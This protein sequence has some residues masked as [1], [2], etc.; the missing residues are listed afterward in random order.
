MTERTVHEVP[1]EAAEGPAAAWAAV[2]PAARMPAAATTTTTTTL[3]ATTTGDDN[4]GG[5]MGNERAQASDGNNIFNN[6]RRSAGN[7]EGKEKGK[8]S[9][10]WNWNKEKEKEKE[11]KRRRESMESNGTRGPD[12]KESRKDDG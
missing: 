1:R 9:G 3:R 8:T 11:K 7:Q 2:A 5:G 4:G 12:S 6:L 10:G